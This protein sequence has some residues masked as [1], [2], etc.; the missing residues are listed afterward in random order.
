MLSILYTI[1]SFFVYPVSLILSILLLP[2]GGVFVVSKATYFVFYVLV[3]WIIASRIGKFFEGEFNQE[4]KFWKWPFGI[5][6][7]LELV[8]FLYFNFF[9]SIPDNYREDYRFVLALFIDAILLSQIYV[10]VIYGVI[11]RR[12]QKRFFNTYF[13][14]VF[15]GVSLLMVTTESINLV[16]NIAERTGK[17]CNTSFLNMS[18]LPECIHRKAISEGNPELCSKIS[19]NPCITEIAINKRDISICDR[20]IKNDPSNKFWNM[21]ECYYRVLSITEEVPYCAQKERIVE[22]YTMV[23][24]EGFPVNNLP[25]TKSAFVFKYKSVFNDDINKMYDFQM[26]FPA[27]WYLTSSDE[28]NFHAYDCPVKSCRNEITFRQY[29]KY[30]DKFNFE[31]WLLDVKDTGIKDAVVLSNLIQ[32]AQVPRHSAGVYDSGF[33]YVYVIYFPNSKIYTAILTKTTEPEQ[34]I[35]PTFKVL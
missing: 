23:K 9:I 30:E 25:V 26:I 14:P 35:M 6:L 11:V 34:T 13:I 22:C 4:T 10:L 3:F 24:S 1:A 32:G 29:P 5:L 20:Y 8:V 12:K 28:V 16:Q 27:G 17:F 19:N 18:S 2:I 7:G 31:K 21:D 33:K 15:I